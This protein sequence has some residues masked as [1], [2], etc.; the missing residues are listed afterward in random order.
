MR[1]LVRRVVGGRW[2]RLVGRS[3][4]SNSCTCRVSTTATTTSDPRSHDTLYTGIHDIII[5][6]YCSALP[7]S[8]EAWSLLLTVSGNAGRE[9]REGGATSL[10]GGGERSRQGDAGRPGRGAGAGR[11][12]CWAHRGSAGSKRFMINCSKTI[13]LLVSY[14]A[15]LRQLDLELF[16]L[17]CE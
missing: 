14:C 15:I 8:Q 10:P 12:G 3:C 17:C 9:R 7:S 4:S 2:A 16:S 11:V 1:V 6:T 13:M 5:T